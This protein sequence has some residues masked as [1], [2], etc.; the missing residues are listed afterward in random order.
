M[1]VRQRSSPVWASSAAAGEQGHHVPLSV[2]DRR[3]AAAQLPFP[4]QPQPEAL[5]KGR[6]G[7]GGAVGSGAPPA[8][9]GLVLLGG[10]QDG[11]AAADRQE[12][13]REQQQKDEDDDGSL[14]LSHLEILSRRGRH[15]LDKWDIPA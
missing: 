10:R 8:G 13:G 6:A 11:Y 1:L 9:P 3:V 14:D 5:G 7:D 2:G 15:V 4:A 12:T